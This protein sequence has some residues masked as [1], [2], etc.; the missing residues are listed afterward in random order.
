MATVLPRTEP[1]EARSI[2]LAIAILRSS[3]TRCTCSTIDTGDLASR[4]VRMSADT[5]LG[6]QEPP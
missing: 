6:K 2:R 5:S 4:A 1:P 3:L